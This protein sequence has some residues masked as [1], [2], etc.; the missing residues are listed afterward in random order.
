M[1][2]S[3]WLTIANSILRVY[4]ATIDTSENLTKLAE[5]VIKVYYQLLFQIITQ[6][7]LEYGARHLRKLIHLSR[8]LPNDISLIINK[9]IQDIAYFMYRENLIS[10]PADTRPHVREVVV[11]R[12]LNTR[13]SAFKNRIFKVSK[14][15]FEAVDHIDL[16]LEARQNSPTF[17]SKFQYYASRSE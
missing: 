15:N 7:K 5:F 11:R 4:V 6:P 10:M 3:R 16:K 13:R 1:G 9:V 14:I 2:H 12:V 17:E 8:D